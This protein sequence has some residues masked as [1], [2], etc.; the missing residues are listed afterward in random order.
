MFLNGKIRR[1]TMPLRN[2]LQLCKR[3]NFG[4]GKKMGTDRYSHCWS[5]VCC[6]HN[7][8]NSRHSSNQLVEGR[9]VC[10]GESVYLGGGSVYLGGGS[11]GEEV[12][13]G[14]WLG[15]GSWLGVA[16]WLEWAKRQDRV[17]KGP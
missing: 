12:L 10:L 5:M 1:L 7:N 6:Y 14:F 2:L 16:F 8:N 13:G 3:C 11:E 17:L 4:R 9:S 15:A